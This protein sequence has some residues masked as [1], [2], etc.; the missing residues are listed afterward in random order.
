VIRGQKAGVVRE[1]LRRREHG[2][3]VQIAGRYGVSP[4]LVAKLEREYLLERR[5]GAWVRSATSWRRGL[6]RVIREVGLGLCGSEFHHGAAVLPL[7][8]MARPSMC[9]DCLRKYQAEY[10]R[11]RSG[12]WRRR[13]VL[14]AAARST[15][16]KWFR[17]RGW[18]WIP[19]QTG[20]VGIGLRG[21]GALSVVFCEPPCLRARRLRA[22]GYEVFVEGVEDFAAWAASRGLGDGCKLR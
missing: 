1:A 14:S 10:V 21:G 22:E 4:S 9:L 6:R 8:S 16:A 5:S 15:A 12:P 2:T 3:T 20:G 13:A 11:K 7:A 18:R 19:T 17:A